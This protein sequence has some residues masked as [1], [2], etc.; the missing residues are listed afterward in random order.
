MLR[1]SGEFKGVEWKT[2]K[3]GKT[4]RTVAVVLLQVPLPVD[5]DYVAELEQETVHVSY[6]NPDVS[7]VVEAVAELGQTRPVDSHLLLVGREENQDIRFKIVHDAKDFPPDILG[8]FAQLTV[9]P[10]SQLSVEIQ[11]HTPQLSLFGEDGDDAEYA[12]GFEG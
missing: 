3:R 12:A 4:V 6:T 1:V 7:L 9:M 2:E 10:E 11:R 5:T 8:Q